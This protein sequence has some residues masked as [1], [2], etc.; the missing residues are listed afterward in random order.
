MANEQRV[1]THTPDCNPCSD[2][3]GTGCIWCDGFGADPSPSAM[4]L[5]ACADIERIFAPDWS[6]RLESA[7]DVAT[8]DL[9]DTQGYYTRSGS[10]GDL[11]EV[12]FVE[13]GEGS[14]VAAYVHTDSGL[15]FMA[16]R[17]DPLAA[18]LADRGFDVDTH[19]RHGAE[20]Q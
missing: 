4:I 6:A 1:H 7:C 9:A 8:Q 13:W 12:I 16:D 5:S 20:V 10:E 17:H 19:T 11:V 14:E 18:C 15:A 2:C 3:G